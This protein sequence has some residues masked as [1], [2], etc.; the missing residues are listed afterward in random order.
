MRRDGHGQLV[1]AE[2]DAGALFLGERE[3]LLQLG[4]RGDA[5]AELPGGAVPVGGRDVFIFPIAR[6]IGAELFLREL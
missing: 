3:V 4:E 6:G 5:V 2:E 1:A